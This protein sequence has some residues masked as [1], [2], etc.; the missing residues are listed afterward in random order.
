[1]KFHIIII[2]LRPAYPWGVAGAAARVGPSKHLNPVLQG[3]DA[4]VEFQ[5]KTNQDLQHNLAN[6]FWDCPDAFD[7]LVLNTAVV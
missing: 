4:L 7:E 2:F 1:M 6:E 5:G 3:V